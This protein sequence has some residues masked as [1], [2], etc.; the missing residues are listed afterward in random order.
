MK[1]PKTQQ[2]EL[3]NIKQASNWLSD[4][5][6]TPKMLFDKFWFEGELCI[7]FADTNLGKSILAMQIANSLACAQQIGPFKNEVEP[8]KVLYFD[9]EHTGSQFEARYTADDGKF[10]F[11]NTLYRAELNTAAL[12]ALDSA[13]DIKAAIEQAIIK[14]GANILVIDNLTYLQNETGKAK[15]ALLLMQHLKALKNK[16]NLSILALAHTPKRLASKPLTQ[17][18]LVGSKM[19]IN[20]CDSA[21]AIGR[22]RNDLDIRY[23]KQIKQRSTAEEYGEDNVCLFNI[24]KNGNFLAFSF[25]DYDD[26][27][28]HLRRKKLKSWGDISNVVVELSKRGLSQRRIAT[29]LSITLTDVHTLLKRAGQVKDNEPVKEIVQVKPK[30]SWEVMEEIRSAALK[31]MEEAKANKKAVK[32]VVAFVTNPVA[33]QVSTKSTIQKQGGAQHNCCVNSG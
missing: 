5:Y 4:T 25:I 27:F 31:R 24:V 26:E 10:S 9:F 11:S 1:A 23:L 28:N 8:C 32:Q 7:L 3:F 20:F 13:E 2:E 18:D 33:A 16:Y 17:N 12:A 19:L 21:F 30:S 6:T 22:S 15:D 29:R 14:T